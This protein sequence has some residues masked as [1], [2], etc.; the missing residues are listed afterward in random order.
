MIQLTKEHKWAIGLI[1][2]DGNIGFN[3]DHTNK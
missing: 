1:E 3:N 2:A